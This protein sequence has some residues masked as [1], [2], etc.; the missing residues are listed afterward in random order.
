MAVE[1]PTYYIEGISD[2]EKVVFKMA[3]ALSHNRVK[4]AP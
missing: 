2:D 1:C 4:T 3:A